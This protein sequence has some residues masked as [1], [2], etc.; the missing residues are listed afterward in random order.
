MQLPIIAVLSEQTLVG[1]AFHNL[2]V[3][4]HT[5]LIGI[6]DRTQTV[7]D[8]HGGTCLHQTLQSILYQTLAFGVE[9]RGSFIEDEDRGILQDGT[10]DGDTLALTTREPFAASSICC[11]VA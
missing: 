8:G 7:G 2:S 9:S 6:L 1:A 3:V 4:E 5:D 10:G 11:R